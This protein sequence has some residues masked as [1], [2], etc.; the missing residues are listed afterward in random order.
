VSIVAI[1][2]GETV[3]SNPTPRETLAP[4]DRAAV[5]G[6]AT[7]IAEAARLFAGQIDTSSSAS[8]QHA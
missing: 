2:R 7:E 6:S 3:I 8:V 5:L 1:G 4:G